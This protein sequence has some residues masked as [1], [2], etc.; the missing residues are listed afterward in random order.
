MT[1]RRR[2]RSSFRGRA[3]RKKTYWDQNNFQANTT[4]VG[5]TSVRDISH[6]LITGGQEA[7]GTCLRLVGN[8]N[9]MQIAASFEPFNFGVGVAV[10]TNDALAAGAV[11]DPLTDLTHD[12]Y[13]WYA[14]EG[15]LGFEVQHTKEFDI[16]SSRR[17]REG[18]RL[19]WVVQNLIQE[20]PGQL[21]CNFRTLWTLG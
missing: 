16:C 6:I 5:F 10:I 17:L 14:W 13:F 7:G 1:T 11:P 15:N 2:S 19:V 4:A 21:Q 12:W 9:Y 3:A 8:M 18:Y 20:L